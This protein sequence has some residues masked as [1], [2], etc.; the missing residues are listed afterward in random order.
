MVTA[1]YM[2]PHTSSIAFTIQAIAIATAVAVQHVAVAVGIFHCLRCLQSLAI[3]C[4]LLQLSVCCC[5]Q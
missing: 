1:N 3:A 4:L 5:P 2:L